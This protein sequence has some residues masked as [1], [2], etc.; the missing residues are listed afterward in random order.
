M[1]EPPEEIVRQLYSLSPEG[2]VAGR[3]A[4][5]ADARKA[6]RPDVAAAIGKL[7][8]PTVAAWAVNLLAHG[9]PDLIEELLDLADR[10]R[11]AQHNLRGDEIRELSGRRRA[12]LGELLSRA[13]DLAAEADSAQGRPARPLPMAEVETTLGAALADPRAAELVRAGRLTRSVEYT[14]FGE[15]PRPRLRL[16]TTTDSGP[17]E[18]LHPADS[19]SSAESR[20]PADSQRSAGS[21]RSGDSRLSGR[22]AEVSGSEEPPGSAEVSGSAEET[23]SGEASGSAESPGSGEASG[24]AEAS[25]PGRRRSGE[26]VTAGAAARA[27]ERGGRADREAQRTPGREPVAEAV[28]GAEAEA[29]AER[30]RVTLEGA[31]RAERTAGDALKRAAADLEEARQRYAETQVALGRAKLDRRRAKRA[32]EQAARRLAGLRH[33]GR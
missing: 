22:P 1:V 26:P 2:F 9:R 29:E 21:Q 18:P 6:G 13:R 19:Q 4:A 8:R 5:V 12:L 3:D 15:T 27:A 20:R 31:E 28:R 10:L 11:A 7:R 23:G 24:S 17:A 25:G 16:I 14:G 32:A 33:A 30:A